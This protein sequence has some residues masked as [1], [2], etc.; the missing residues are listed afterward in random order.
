MGRWFRRPWTWLATGVLAGGVAYGVVW[1]QD[2]APAAKALRDSQAPALSAG[3][4]TNP[5]ADSVPGYAGSQPALEA[6]ADDPDALKATGAGAHA[7]GGAAVDLTN[8]S[9]DRRNA[10]GVSAADAWLGVSGGVAADPMARVNPADAT[11]AGAEGEA[12]QDV[13]HTETT[14]SR[15]IY[16]CE[17]GVEYYVE[18]HSCD[19]RYEPNVQ[20]YAY[21]CEETYN[22]ATHAWVRSSNCD[23]AANDGNCT[24]GS[25]TCSSPTNP[26]TETYACSEGYTERTTTTAATYSCREGYT[27]GAPTP[28]SCSA[29]YTPNIQYATIAGPCALPTPQN[30]Y[31]DQCGGAWGMP[32]AGCVMVDESWDAAGGHWATFACDPYDAGGAYDTSSCS[33]MSGCTQ[34]GATCVEGPATYTFDGAAVY[35]DCWRYQYDYICTGGRVEAPGCFPPSG[36]TLTGSSCAAT[37]ASGGCTLWNRDYSYTTTTTVRDPATGCAP[38]SGASLTNSSCG[39]TDASGGCTLWNRTYAYEVPDEAGACAAYA[40]HYDCQGDTGGRWIPGGACNWS[41]L[42]NCRNTATACTDGP[43]TRDVGGVPVTAC[44][45][46]Q[47]T[48]EC[49]LRRETSNCEVPDGCAHVEDACLDDPPAGAGG[50]CLTTDH[51][52]ACETTT[53]TTTTVN[54]CQ[55]RM[56]LGDSCFTLERDANDEFPQVF[57]QLS[58]MKEAGE[59]YA[60]NP[61]FQIFKG[62]RLA[63]KKAV[64]GFRNCCKD[65]GWGISLGLAH[66]SEAEKQLIAKQETKAT[67]YVG[68][69]CS[70]RSLFGCLEKS[71][72]YCAFEGALGRV[73][74]E[75]GRPQI[76]KTWGTA[77]SPDC[78]GFTVDQFQQLD[79]SDVDFSDF[80]RD[81]LKDFTSPDPDATA[82]RIQNSLSN[83]YSEGGNPDGPK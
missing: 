12:C 14:T 59:D 65:S 43:S 18:T 58:A 48:Y 30:G 53:T 11:V 17:T 5:T 44:W 51:R 81:K 83:L 76:G 29:G 66:C 50:E 78:S 13:E 9:T 7:A 33:G 67:H 8:A 55:S 41:G 27:E 71:M 26:H 37:D 63:C 28:A 35:R 57:S 47:L 70:N 10:A 62:A 64:L 46:R 3:P 16:T 73:V 34:T 1:A 75:T 2:Q 82:S 4:T 31:F 32:R 79:L 72:V 23:V 69:Y 45:N 77:K 54:T 49:T 68:T 38:P 52:Y 24:A 40:T 25:R 36:A 20:T 6:F 74:Q 19:E 80:Y 39:A 61:D 56:C 21:V 60:T 15:S 42:P 22:Y